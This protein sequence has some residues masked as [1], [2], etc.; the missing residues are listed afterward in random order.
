[1]DPR[2]R[3][4]GVPMVPD[5]PMPVIRIEQTPANDLYLILAM[6]LR[7]PTIV[8]LFQDPVGFYRAH[9]ESVRAV[10]RYVERAD[11][12]A[13]PNATAAGAQV[14]RR[15]RQDTFVSKHTPLLR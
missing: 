10:W 3:E 9:E 6:L 4:G 1:M 7:T 14:P 13:M 5:Q 12:E 15:A 2:R 11:P 8:H